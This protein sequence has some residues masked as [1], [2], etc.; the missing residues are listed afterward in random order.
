M[1]YELISVIFFLILLAIV[2]YRDRR[3]IEFKSGLI[4][5]KSTRGRKF[6]YSF[7]AK[8]ERTLKIIGN[9]G[10]IVSFLASFYG[11]Y[12]LFNSTYKIISKKSTESALKV[13]L[14][15]VEGV[16]MPGFVLGV[17]FWYW[18][19][20][21]FVV[22]AAH[23]PMHALLARVER[24]RIKSFGLLL[25]IVLPGAFVEPDELQLK[26]RST[27]GKLRIFAGGSFANLIIAALFIFLVFLF[28]KL[29]SMILEPTGVSYEALIEGSY[30]EK[31]GLKGTIIKLNDREIRTISDLSDFMQTIKPGEKIKVVT[32]ENVYEIETIKD[33]ESERALI[34]IKNPYVEYRYKG[35]LSKYGH[36]SPSTLSLF[37]WIEG[38]F[39]WIFILN[40]GVGVFN[41]FPLKP[42][43]GGLMFEAVCEH[44]F[45]K[46]SKRITTIVSVTLLILILFNIFGPSL[47]KLIS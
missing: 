2:I 44:F 35:F 17:P 27:L 21:V 8:H 43:D 31:V 7:A 16:K 28:G 37:Q 24:V 6:I 9:I 13:V 45:K 41:L 38:L 18:I 5:R 36:V 26:K 23:E 25:F 47:L 39:Y 1:N 33:E 34:G 10:I 12:L 11:L 15:S 20:A 32:T 46:K 14:P 4:I 22:M 19:I 42:L 29:L 40:V 30:A 3:N